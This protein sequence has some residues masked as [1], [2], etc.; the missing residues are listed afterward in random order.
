MEYVRCHTYFTKKYSDLQTRSDPITSSAF[1]PTI[2]QMV[3][4]DKPFISVLRRYLRCFLIAWENLGEPPTAASYSLHSQRVR[5]LGLNTELTLSVLNLVPVNS[6]SITV[7]RMR[8][9]IERSKALGVVI[10]AR[11]TFARQR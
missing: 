8:Y 4:P 11:W 5:I 7:S 6:I 2:L 10:S 1:L 3:E 9:A